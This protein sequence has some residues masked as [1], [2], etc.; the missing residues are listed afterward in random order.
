MA[1]SIIVKTHGGMILRA[2]AADIHVTQN[3]V[4]VGQWDMRHNLVHNP[5]LTYSVR[6]DDVKAIEYA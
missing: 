2:A 5:K 6:P 3:G 4:L 1:I